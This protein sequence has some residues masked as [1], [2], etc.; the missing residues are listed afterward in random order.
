M[1]QRIFNFSAGP[2]TL[3]EPVLIQ[4]RDEFLNYNNTGM[5]VMEM[6]HRS[7]DFQ[8][9]RDEAEQTIRSVLSIPEDYAVL[10][11]Q[12]GATTQFSMVP[13]NLYQAGKPVSFIHTGSWTKKALKELKKVGDVTM[14]GS[15]EG[16]SFNR[17]PTEINID[18]NSSYAYLC[19]NNTI[20]GTQFHDFPDTGDVPLVADM[21]SDILSRPID[22]SSFGLIF[23]GAQKNAG[24]AGVTLVI[25]KK[26]LIETI[27]DESMPSMLNYKNHLDADSLFNT[28]PTYSIYMVGLVA[29][30]ILDQGGINEIERRNQS[31]AQALYEFIDTSRLYYATAAEGSRSLM[32]VTFRIKGD[33]SDL[34]TQFHKQAAKH[35]LSGLKGHRLVGGLRA[36]IYNAM[37]ESGIEA[38]ISFMKQF[39]EENI[40]NVPV[41][42]TA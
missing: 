31:K 1:S 17:I 5:S 11:L 33:L 12:G 41:A 13:M 10:F 29:K 32:N 34:E 37:P 36:S 3:P 19:S 6:S 9:I 22:I 25:V 21:S 28:C 30:W 2:A 39:E 35:G 14:A 42:M 20:Y 40:A 16:D 38:L 7:S 15:S 23:A 18:P 27:T 24:P 8:A 4:A 26:S